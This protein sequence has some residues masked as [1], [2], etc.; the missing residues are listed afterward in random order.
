MA[1][2]LSAISAG[3]LVGAANQYACLLVVGLA[4]RAGLIT[5][6]GPMA[7]M[8]DWWF[9]AVAAVL[10]LISIAPSF[11]QHLAPGVMHVVNWLTHFINGFVVPVSSALIGLAATGVI[12]NLDPNFKH[13]YE[14]LQIFSTD[15]ALTGS[16][17][18]VAG[19]S[20]VAAVTLTA[21]K[22]LAKPMISTGTGT[23]GTVSAPAF[24]TAENIAAVVLMGLVYGLSQIDP[25]LLIGLA[26]VVLLF[27][28]ALLAYGLYQLYRLKKGV[29]RVL[30]L[31]ERDPRAGLAVAAEFGIWGV[32]WLTY[33]HY[34][35]AAISL[36]AWALWLAVFVA[37]QG[38][39]TALLA[40]APPLIPLG[41]VVV[42]VAL[43][44]V[45][46]LVGTATARSLLHV[47][48]RATPVRAM[49]ASA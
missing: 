17:V 20:A 32:G 47:A 29:G 39:V 3:G 6:S 45:F 49:A 24:T 21:V 43:L 48:E 44:G 11:S 30:A 14:T 35:R 23:A 31:A 36:C 34:G 37:A 15:G 10:W 26:V 7:F 5:L 27:C 1:L 38:A 16:G 25:R 28:V 4:A 9:I 12:L 2:V 19:G 22:G 33:G 13:L 8:G 18:A 41:I 42:N 40:V 46:A